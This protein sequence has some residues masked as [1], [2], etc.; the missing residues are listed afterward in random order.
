MSGPQPGAFVAVLDARALAPGEHTFRFDA[1]FTNG[2]MQSTSTQMYVQ[3]QP[4]DATQYVSP[5]V[6]I[7]QPVYQLPP[8]DSRLELAPRFH[9]H[10]DYRDNHGRMVHD[11]DHHGD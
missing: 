3:T 8:S 10:V 9:R 11:R 1:R 5:P 4:Y 2:V 6:V 7:E